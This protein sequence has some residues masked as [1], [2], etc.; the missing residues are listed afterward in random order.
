VADNLTKVGS[1]EIFTIEPNWANDISTEYTMSRRLISY[2]GTVALLESIAQEV[3][4]ALSLSFQ[5]GG[6]QE[7]YELLTFFL[8][9][10]GRLKRFWLK[11]PIASFSLKTTAAAGAAGI[12]CNRNSFDLIYRGY[13]RICISMADGDIVVRKVTSCLAGSDYT[14]LGFDTVIDRDITEDNCSMISRFLLG[15]FNSDKLKFSYG[16]VDVKTTELSFVELVKEYQFA[17]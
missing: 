13:E 12:Y 7:E 1:F 15:R 11:S 2:P 14:Y 8:S 17:D 9:K 6:R 10:L 4:I 3:P 16:S 5:C